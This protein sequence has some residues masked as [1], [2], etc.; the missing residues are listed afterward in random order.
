MNSPPQ[1]VLIM[2]ATASGKT[3]LA[4]SLA[5]RYPFDI[6]SVDSAM[7][8]RGMDIGTA[9]P[10]KQTLARFPHQLVDILDP[11][12]AYSAAEFCRDANQAIANSLEQGRWPLLVGG[13]FLYFNAWLHGLSNLPSADTE[14]REQLL[15]RA[16]Q[17]GWAA[18]HRELAEHDAPSAARIHPNDPQR[19]QRAL[20]VYYSS[21]KPLSVWHAEEQKSASAYPSYKLI[22]APEDRRVL[23]SRIEKRFQ[24]MLNQGLV[25]EVELLFRRP[26]LSADLPSI[27]SVGYRQVWQWLSGEFSYTELQERAVIATRQFAKRQFTWLRRDKGLPWIDPMRGQVFEKAL[28]KLK[29][30]GFPL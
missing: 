13:T 8:Y 1:V 12:Q 29:I 6:I 2:G 19:I 30:A 10:D 25:E 23:D 16:Q 21:G 22:L 26:D 11:A 9:K 20:E 28:E 7:V 15:A 18:M 24:L 14:L 4:L 17:V 5:E 3:D 27:R